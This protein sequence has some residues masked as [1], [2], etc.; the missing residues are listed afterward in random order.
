MT[1]NALVVA[2]ATCA[3]A[4]ESTGTP[5]CGGTL[6]TVGIDVGIAGGSSRTCAAT[7]LSGSVVLTS[8]RC[9]EGFLAVQASTPT[10]AGP[11]GHVE[12][13][14]FYAWNRAVYHSQEHDLAV[15]V[16]S[17][18]MV[19]HDTAS[20]APAACL[21]CDVLAVQ[22]TAQGALRVSSP[23][24]VERR[25]PLGRPFSLATQSDMDQVTI[26]AG[27]KRVS[28]RALLGVFSGRGSRTG[29]GYFARL[30]APA[31]MIWLRARCARPATIRV[32]PRLRTDR[33]DLEI[34]K[35]GFARSVVASKP[36]RR[37]VPPRA[38]ERRPAARAARPRPICA[39]RHPAKPADESK[40]DR[41]SMGSQSPT[42]TVM[43]A[44]T[45]GVPHL[46]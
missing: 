4:Q 30:D 26:G 5:E 38:P 31:A 24:A 32:L 9:L 19:T 14:L 41:F 45:R 21:A 43:A 34:P 3:S 15:L 18:S 6:D 39:H 25:S 27:I 16:L 42:K 36:T 29:K 40:T 44:R 17:H 2:A 7:L 11:S 37:W 33:T 28:D 35:R 8:A 13:V 46:T 12:R 1:A 20:V 10:I 23:A 22:R